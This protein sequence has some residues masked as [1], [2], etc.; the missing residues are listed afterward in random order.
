MRRFIRLAALMITGQVLLW[1]ILGPLAIWLSPRLDFLEVLIFAYWPTI[2]L[3]ELTGHYV[4]DANI[5]EP[6]LY[7]VLLGIPL[8][9]IIV[10]TA[11]CLIKRQRITPPDNLSS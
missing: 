9:A 8:N 5:I 6:L 10:A 7:G 3:F 11:V 2:R 1:I 4:G